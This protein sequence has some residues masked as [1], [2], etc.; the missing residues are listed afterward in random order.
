MRILLPVVLRKTQGSPCIHPQFSPQITH[1]LGL[2]CDHTLLMGQ[3]LQ[4]A[5]VLSTVAPKFP[6]V[7]L[8]KENISHLA[9]AYYFAHIAIIKYHCLGDLNNRS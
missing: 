2:Y 1:T 4:L 8:N 7:S 9:C 5:P 6:K 3:S